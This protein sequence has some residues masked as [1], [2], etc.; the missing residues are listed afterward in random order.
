MKMVKSASPHIRG[1]ARC[2]V[3]STGRRSSRKGQAGRIR[4]GLLPVRRRVLLHPRHRHLHEGRRLCPLPAELWHRATAS[5][6]ARS[7]APVACNTRRR[8]AGLRQRVRAR[9]R[10]RHPPADRVRHVAHVP[11]PGLHAGHR[12]C[13]HDQR[14][15]PRRCTSTRGFIQI[16]GFTFGKATSF[17]DFV[18]TAA[19]AYN[20]GCV[21]HAR[22]P[23][24]RARW[25]RAYTAQFGNGLS[26]TISF[27][28]SRRAAPSICAS[29]GRV[30]RLR[31]RNRRLPTTSAG[32]AGQRRLP[33][34]RRQPPRRPGLGFCPD[35]RALLHD[36]SAA[37]TTGVGL[38]LAI[39]NGNGHPEQQVGLGG[40]RRSEAQLPDDRTWR[41]LPG[42][43]RSTRKARRSMLSQHAAWRRPGQVERQHVRLSASGEDGVFTGTGCAPGS[44]RADHRLERVRIVRA[45]LDAGLRTSL[46]GSYVELRTTATANDGD[47]RHQTRCRQR[48]SRAGCGLRPGLAARGRSA[49]V[50]SGTSPRTSTSVST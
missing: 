9:Q 2:G 44:Y 3:G 35:R 19:V 36:V 18:S 37:S 49:R 34:H 47:L 38:A 15:R 11:D 28:Q 17:F 23:A 48:R 8:L 5:P 30:Q 50:R 7:R 13:E 45:L 26:G 42:P 32:A 1:G 41:L 20:A 16:A 27:E 33:G 24:T 31:W 6:A 22:T 40:Q 14:L 39:A 46:Y 25:L 29:P 12:P 4:E 21:P 43:G 10:R